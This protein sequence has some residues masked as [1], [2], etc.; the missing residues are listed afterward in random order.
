MM[1]N[2]SPGTAAHVRVRSLS[3]V[4]APVGKEVMVTRDESVALVALGNA[5]L[6]RDDAP[7]SA[8][9]EGYER[10]DIRAKENDRGYSRKSRD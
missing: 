7:G 9:S 5:A 6:V 8:R 4:F 2:I 3:K 10:A 1:K